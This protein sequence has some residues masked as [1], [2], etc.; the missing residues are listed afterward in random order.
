VLG[1]IREH[2]T[3]AHTELEHTLR[4]F[5]RHDGQWGVT[6]AALHVH[7][8]TL[9]NRMARITELTGRNVNRLEDTVDLFL[10]LAAETVGPGTASHTA[11]R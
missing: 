8:N 6:A 5:L 3:R 1:I 4:T 7:V 9:R 10:A 2:D 11:P